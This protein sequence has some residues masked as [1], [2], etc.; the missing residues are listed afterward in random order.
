M[1]NFVLAMIAV[2]AVGVFADSASAQV[3][4]RRVVSKT[5]CK[6]VQTVKVAPACQPAP[7]ASCETACDTSCDKNCHVGA[8]LAAPVK[9]VA[10][11]VHAVGHAVSNALDCRSGRCQTQCDTNGCT[12]IVAPVVVAPQS[13]A[14]PDAAAPA[15]PVKADVPAVAPSASDLPKNSNT[16][17]N[18]LNIDGV[19]YAQ[20]PDGTYANMQNGTYTRLTAPSGDVFYSTNK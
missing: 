20:L 2:F 7:V 8:L 4:G 6:T 11:T 18:I 5:T 15:P 14:K 1:K 19:P 10:G 3:F 16:H 17:V 9:V 13:A 12:V